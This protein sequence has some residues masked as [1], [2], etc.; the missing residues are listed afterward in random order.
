MIQHDVERR[1][2][3]GDDPLDRISRSGCRGIRA[4]GVSLSSH[5]HIMGVAVRETTMEMAMATERTTANSRNRRPTTPL[6]IRMGMKTAISE[7]LIDKTVKPISS[8]PLRAACIGFMPFSMWRVMFSITTI[9]SSTTN[10]VAMV[11][12][13]SER[14]SRVYPIRYIAPNVAMMDT[15]TDTLGMNVDQPLR[16]KTNTTKITSPM[17]MIMLRWASC[18]RIAG[19]DGAV[20]GDLETDR[21][22]KLGLKLR[23]QGFDPRDRVDDIRIRLAVDLDLHHRIAVDDAEVP[24]IFVAV[25][26]AAEVRQADGRALAVDHHQILVFLRQEKLVAGIDRKLSL[27]V[28]E[29]AF[30]AVRVGALQERADLIEPHVVVGERLRIHLDANRGKRASAHLTP[31]RRRSPATASAQTP[32]KRC[33]TA[34]ASAR[35]PIRASAAGS[36]G[37]PD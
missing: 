29:R 25:D 6:I 21:R 34:A 23:H 11:S 27:G 16:R 33:R 35:H 1:R 26:D 13:I 15:G 30:G 3:G 12:A 22:R 5:A 14:L 31:G 4:R 10:P 7:M 2:V 36:A 17:E 24:D 8:A 28:R 20:A 9:A 32:R 37:R 19:G 18:M